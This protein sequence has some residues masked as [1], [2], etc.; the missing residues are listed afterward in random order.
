VKEQLA[1]STCNEAAGLGDQAQ[2]VPSFARPL[3]HR[4]CKRAVVREDET[5]GEVA[6]GGTGL[7]RVMDREELGDAPPPVDRGICR[8]V[9]GWAS[10]LRHPLQ[11]GCS[12]EPQGICCIALDHDRWDRTARR[13]AHAKAEP[14]GAVRDDDMAFGVGSGFSQRLRTERKRYGIYRIG[15]FK[16]D[17]VRRCVRR[18][19]R[20]ANPGIGFGRE[21][22]KSD[23]IARPDPPLPSPGFPEPK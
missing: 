7:K 5:E 3:P 17:D 11:T 2:D 10:A 19:Q 18:P 16:D 1:I 4:P 9:D 15:G 22:E 12:S 14:S 21:R 8:A 13:M 23:P 6:R 20:G